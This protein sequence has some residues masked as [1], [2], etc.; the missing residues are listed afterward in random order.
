MVLDQHILGVVG[1]AQ[2]H[3]RP[4]AEPQGHDVPVLLRPFAVIAKD[5]AAEIEQVPKKRQAL[6]PGRPLARPITSLTMSLDR[7]PALHHATPA[8]QRDRPTPLDRF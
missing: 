3:G 2:E 4:G 7:R 1:A 5:V 6:R 8:S